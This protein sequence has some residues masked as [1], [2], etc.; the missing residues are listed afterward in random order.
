MELIIV[1][2]ILFL[3][4]TSLLI[5]IY[6]REKQHQQDRKDMLDRIMSRNFEE[7]KDLTQPL[8][9]FEPVYTDEEEEY[10]R[11]LEEQKV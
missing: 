6:Q 1:S 5:F 9:K 2:I 8:P 11:E 7:Y 10:Y 3:T 4:I